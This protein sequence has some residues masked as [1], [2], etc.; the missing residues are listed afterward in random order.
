MSAQRTWWYAS[1]LAALA[2][3]LVVVLAVNGTTGADASGGEDTTTTEGSSTETPGNPIIEVGNYPDLDSSVLEDPGPGRCWPD[4]LAGRRGQ[5]EAGI[6]ENIDG[7]NDF[8]PPYTELE[9]EILHND[10]LIFVDQNWDWPCVQGEAQFA[11]ENPQWFM[12]DEVLLTIWNRANP[13]NQKSDWN[14]DPSSKDEF[15]TYLGSLVLDDIDPLVVVEN[16]R[17]VSTSDRWESL[18]I[19]KF[20]VGELLFFV[21]GYQPG[22]KKG[23]MWK[24]VYKLVCGNPLLPP[25]EKPPPGTTTT[26]VPDSTTTT[27]HPDVTTTTVPSTTT[28]SLAP[29]DPEK[30]PNRNPDIPDEA[31]VTT[32][33]VAGLPDNPATHDPT[34]PDVIDDGYC[35]S[36]DEPTTPP[37]VVTTTTTMWTDESPTTTTPDLGSGGDGSPTCDPGFSWINGE[38]CV[39][40]DTS[41][42]EGQTNDGAAPQ[43]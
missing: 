25:G 1:A 20:P 17:W 42:G 15:L 11:A 35:Q 24:P 13:D 39:A 30:L 27:T 6:F 41:S 4:L 37:I 23:L 26:T 38:G 40:A 21:P 16:H 33:A 7:V 3:V 19:Q 14:F 2:A 22:N 8:T 34:N 29:K 32:P 12:A 9:K 5:V 28:T 36:C 10:V 43:P 18:G 31:K